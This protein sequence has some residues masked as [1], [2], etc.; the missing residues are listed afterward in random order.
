MSKKLSVQVA[1]ILG[2]IV[3]IALYPAFVKRPG[4]LDAL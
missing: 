2:P 4:A 3:L 1:F